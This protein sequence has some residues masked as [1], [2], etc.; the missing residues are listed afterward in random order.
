M[1]K[2]DLVRPRDYD[3]RNWKTTELAIFLGEYDHPFGEWCYVQTVDGRRIRVPWA[4]LE[5]VS[6]GT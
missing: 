4:R 1:K 6:E 5:V 2:G 3:Y